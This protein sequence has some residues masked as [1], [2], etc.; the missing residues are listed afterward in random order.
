MSRK[1]FV[2]AAPIVAACLLPSAAAAAPDAPAA[3]PA[4]QRTLVAPASAKTDCSSKPLT[5]TGVARTTYT[6]LMSGFVTARAGGDDA[7]DWDL[8]LFD[9]ASGQQLS[10]SQGFGSHE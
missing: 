7:G 8:G 9:A 10:S 2:A 5:G 1:L 6:A 3:L 4:I